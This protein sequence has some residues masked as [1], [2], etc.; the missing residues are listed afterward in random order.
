MWIKPL[1]KN[2][3]FWKKTYEK[4][5]PQEKNASAHS[6]F[7]IFRSLP[8]VSCSFVCQNSLLTSSFHFFIFSISFARQKPISSGQKAMYISVSAVQSSGSASPAA[9]PSSLSQAKNTVETSDTVV[10]SLRDPQWWRRNDERSE[11]RTDVPFFPELSSYISPS[12][13]SNLLK[14]LLFISNELYGPGNWIFKTFP[15]SPSI[16]SIG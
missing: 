8:T 11:K 14:L 15:C 1:V 4:T 3:E 7:S 5:F 13:L 16:K 2:S 9:R 6:N 10:F 12:P